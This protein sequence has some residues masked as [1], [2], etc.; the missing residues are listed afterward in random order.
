MPSPTGPEPTPLAWLA[1]GYEWP[2]G[3]L[4]ES[5]PAEA[6]VVREAARRTLAALLERSDDIGDALSEL[7]APAR[8]AGGALVSGYRYPD[9]VD[10]V[11]LE[12]ALETRL[13]PS[14]H[15]VPPAN[16]KD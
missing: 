14:P 8:R 12:A 1:K 10:L 9:F 5:A 13:W 6:L 15:E 11:A 3:A 2:A 16:D 4:V 7:P